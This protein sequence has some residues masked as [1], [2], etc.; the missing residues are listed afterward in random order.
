MDF[1]NVGAVRED[2]E[3][4]GREAIEDAGGCRVRIKANLS[5]R[6]LLH[7]AGTA[8][9]FVPGPQRI[10]DIG[11][12]NSRA[13]DRHADLCFSKIAAQCFGKAQHSMF[14]DGVD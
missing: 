8:K 14:R 2:I 1:G 13:D 4:I 12:D 6:S 11:R 7:D 10:P 5:C 3:F 9:A